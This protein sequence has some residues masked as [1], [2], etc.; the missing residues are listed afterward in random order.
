VLRSAANWAEHGS[1]A[2]TGPI[3]RGDEAT[4]ARH[5]EAIAATEPDL[6]DLYR[7]LAERTRAVAL[8]GSREAV[9]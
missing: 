9:R 4:I 8:A 2:L 7:V 3:A 5:L 6:L 1:A